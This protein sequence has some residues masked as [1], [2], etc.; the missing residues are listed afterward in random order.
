MGRSVG[1]P[2]KQ[3]TPTEDD[4]WFIEMQLN[5][6]KIAKILGITLQEL[7]VIA[8]ADASTL[9]MGVMHVNQ[10]RRGGRSPC[11]DE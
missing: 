2:L 9:E 6:R 11:P 8:F 3:L 7:G 5:A 4:L 1:F 10:A